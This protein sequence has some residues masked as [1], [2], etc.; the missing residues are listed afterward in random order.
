M[1]ILYISKLDGRPWVGPTYSVPKQIS[2]QSCYDNI[3]W[4]NFYD[5]GQDEGIKN[6]NIWKKLSYY[7][8]L[9]DFPSGHIADLP[10]PFN[11]PDLIVVEQ[12]YPFARSTIRQEIMKSGIPY[13][14]VPRGEFTHNAQNKKALKKKIGNFVLQIPR[15]VRCGVAIQCLTNQENRETDSFWGNKRIVL[16]NGTDIPN[17]TEKKKKEGKVFVS[18]GRYEPY[19]KGLDLLIAAVETNS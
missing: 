9:S 12:C 17:L 2:A 18:I 14:V 3:F 10:V 6:V 5:G 16:P 1:D 7:A 13:I 11:R 4:F 19:Q 8:D 15:F